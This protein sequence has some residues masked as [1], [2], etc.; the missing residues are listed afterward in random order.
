MSPRAGVTCFF[1]ATLRSGE[2]VSAQGPRLIT[3][4]KLQSGEILSQPPVILRNH[5][6]LSPSEESAS[7]QMTNTREGRREEGRGIGDAAERDDGTLRLC[8]LSV[9]WPGRFARNGAQDGCSDWSGKGCTP[10]EDTCGSRLGACSEMRSRSKE[11]IPPV[12]TC[13]LSVYTVFRT[14]L[15]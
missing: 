5:T 1:G 7:A 11:V 2:K 10:G 14:G 15:Q 3:A 12:L 4:M 6:E 8:D 9:S 13:P